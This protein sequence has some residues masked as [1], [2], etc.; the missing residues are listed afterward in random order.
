MRKQRLNQPLRWRCVRGLSS[1]TVEPV[2][3]FSDD[4]VST[5]QDSEPASGKKNAVGADGHRAKKKSHSKKKTR[6]FLFGNFSR[7]PF[8]L[9]LDG[10]LRHFGGHSSSETRSASDLKQWRSCDVVARKCDVDFVDFR[11]HK[12][13]GAIAVHGTSCS[14]CASDNVQEK[15][16]PRVRYM[17]TLPVR[18]CV[19]VRV[20]AP[21]ECGILS[22]EERLSSTLAMR[23]TK[24]ERVSEP[25][26]STCSTVPKEHLTIL[27]TERLLRE[28]DHPSPRRQLLDKTTRC[29]LPRNRSH[30]QSS[31]N[32]SKFNDTPRGSRGYMVDRTPGPHLHIGWQRHIPLLQDGNTCTY[33]ACHFGPHAPTLRGRHNTPRCPQRLF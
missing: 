26:G 28:P 17:S 33:T 25:D 1:F 15:A 8:K 2:R 31:N 32:I 13:D 5:W 16:S 30:Q 27:S 3:P 12:L 18:A 14:G 9:F 6:M 7:S 22:R 24:F 20:E 21:C 29:G 4:M 10:P 19:T 11:I 23:Q